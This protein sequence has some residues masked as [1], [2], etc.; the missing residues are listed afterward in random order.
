MTKLGVGVVAC[1]IALSGRALATEPPAALTV[2][3]E[4]QQTDQERI[5]RELRR[6]TKGKYTPT[7]ALPQISADAIGRDLPHLRF[8]A[9]VF[10]QWPLGVAP[11]FPL[12][13]SNVIAVSD[14][15]TV[16]VMTEPTAL[17]RLFNTNRHLKDPRMI[18]LAWLNL[19]WHFSDD[20]FFKFDVGQNIT[21]T[22]QGDRT[23]ASG[24]DVVQPRG[25]DQGEID[26]TLIIAANGHLIAASDNR[27]VRPG[28]RPICQATKLLDPDPIVRGMAEQCLLVMGSRA[29]AYLDEQRAKASPELQTAIDAMWQRILEREKSLQE[30][31]TTQPSP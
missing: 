6:I 2:I 5:A 8:Y 4:R 16:T 7:G 11:P 23:L 31:P 15:G 27:N 13:S 22:P 29:R 12:S 21:I 24:K 28:I 14:A 26:V 19:T 30:P 20:R 3:G 1:V 10:P 18:L 25:G 9:L 17:L